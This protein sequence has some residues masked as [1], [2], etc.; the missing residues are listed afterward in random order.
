MKNLTATIGL[1]IAVLLGSAGVTWSADFQKGQVA[2]ERRNYTT[3]LR[4]WEPLAEQGHADAQRGLGELYRIG[5]GVRQNYK[6]AAWW[7]RLASEQ[8]NAP[9]QVKLGEAYSN[10]NGVPQ[11]N[12][13]AY[14]WWSIAASS[15]N[16][17]AITNRDRVAA[18]LNTAQL[19]K[20][21]ALARECARKSYKSC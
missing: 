14:M 20:A 21:Q 15:F 9:A 7:F 6:T 4:E 8:G 16:R 19:E 5:K 3:A 1:T 2:F 11:D 18:K 10:G 13:Y 12:I 17:A